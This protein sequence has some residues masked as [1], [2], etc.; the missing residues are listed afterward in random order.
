MAGNMLQLLTPGIQ[1]AMLT[2]DPQISFF[3]YN[4]RRYSD[5]SLD[6]VMV[7]SSQGNTFLSSSGSRQKYTYD[8]PRSGDLLYKA[9]AVFEVPGLGN[10]SEKNSQSEECKGGMEWDFINQE[11]TQSL[12][13]IE[14]P[15]GAAVDCRNLTSLTKLTISDTTKTLAEYGNLNELFGSGLLSIIGTGTVPIVSGGTGSLKNVMAGGPTNAD[16]THIDKDTTTFDQLLDLLNNNTQCTLEQTRFGGNAGSEIAGNFLTT[17]SFVVDGVNGTDTLS[18]LATHTWSTFLNCFKL[19]PANFS[20]S[21][22][23]TSDA[24]L[25]V[26]LSKGATNTA[27]GTT[28][29]M[30][31]HVESYKERLSRGA[32][33]PTSCGSEPYYIDSLG[34]YLL[35]EVRLVIGSQ[36]V[37]KT[38]GRYIS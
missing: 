36:I 21:V 1:G 10:Y 11:C 15:I 2:K 18:T 13:Q 12:G 19:V 6:M 20:S 37:C 23:L 14:V 30:T 35:D 16:S 8:M 26:T 3:R 7:D 34:Q 32:E 28:Q 9:F 27:A 25:E 31:E 5:F 17:S 38:Y 24:V 33:K 22:P 4:F 29:V